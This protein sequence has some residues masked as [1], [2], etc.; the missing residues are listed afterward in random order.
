[1]PCICVHLSFSVA[2]CAGTP[3]V[4]PLR[5]VNGPTRCAGRVE[6]LHSQQWGT[7]CDDSWDLSD[8][9]VVCQQLGCGTAMSAPGSA[10]FGQGFGRIWLD[11]V[12]CSGRESALSE[13][14]ARPWGIHNCNHGE[15]AGIVCSGNLHP[16][17]VLLGISRY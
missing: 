5:L 6:V 11:D 9:A 1:M 8:A 15:D 3:E 7:I 17:P 13:C 4:P 16:C 2:F 10:Y 14:V 12:K